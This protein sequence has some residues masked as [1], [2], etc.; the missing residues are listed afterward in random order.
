MN[1][2]KEIVPYG[3]GT[4]VK[5]EHVAEMEQKQKGTKTLKGEGVT[6]PGV[7][8]WG[9]EITFGDVGNNKPLVLNVSFLGEYV[10][11]A[12]NSCEL[13]FI[14]PGGLLNYEGFHLQSFCVEGECLENELYGEH[15]PECF[16]ASFIKNFFLGYLPECFLDY[17]TASFSEGECS[18]VF[19]TRGVR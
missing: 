8:Y 3:G 4:N 16:L 2:E 18:V 1:I 7:G 14:T 10:P 9:E 5:G 19:Y 17:R 12:S 11:N 6:R 15:S 13:S